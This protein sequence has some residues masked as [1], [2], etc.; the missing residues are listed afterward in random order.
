M[1]FVEPIKNEKI[2]KYLNHE[3][4]KIQSFYK[5]KNQFD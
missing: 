1:I 2:K 5:T 4:N 3:K